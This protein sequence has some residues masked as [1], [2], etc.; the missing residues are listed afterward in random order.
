MLKIFSEPSWKNTRCG[1]PRIG[2][3]RKNLEKFGKNIFR[4]FRK[5]CGGDPRRRTF[6]R[7]AS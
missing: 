6:P 2:Y 4:T 7:R 1:D 5:F 3:S